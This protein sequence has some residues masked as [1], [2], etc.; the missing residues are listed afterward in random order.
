MALCKKCGKREQHTFHNG[1]TVALCAVCGWNAIIEL[2]DSPEV[3]SEYFPTKAPG[4]CP[5]WYDITE[6][7][8]SAGD[9]EIS[10][11]YAAKRREHVR[12]C[13]VCQSADK[14]DN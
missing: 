10:L 4:Y 9:P 3:Q 8:V 2:V 6:K 5:I 11:G 14:K 1:R 7:Y 13:A 12:N